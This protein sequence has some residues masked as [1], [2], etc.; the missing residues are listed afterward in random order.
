MT[1]LSTIECPKCNKPKKEKDF[2]WHKE[3]RGKV[4]PE[5]KGC[6]RK[7]W[8]KKKNGNVVKGYFNEKQFA[9]LYSF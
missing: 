6:V 8:K 5:C 3:Y 7:R 1:E 2:Y 9:K 4:Y